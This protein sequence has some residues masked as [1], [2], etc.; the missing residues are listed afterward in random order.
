MT[1][2]EKCDFLEIDPAAEGYLLR[3]CREK[4]FEDNLRKHGEL[5]ALVAKTRAS[6]PDHPSLGRADAVLAEL[7]VTIGAYL[8]DFKPQGRPN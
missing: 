1:R 4:R 8:G 2:E 5:S 3:L 6:N 7:N